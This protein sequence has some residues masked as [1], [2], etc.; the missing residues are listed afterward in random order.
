MQSKRPKTKYYYSYGNVV[1]ASYL[2]EF[3]RQAL[4]AVG[5]LPLKLN[6]S[7]YE[8]ESVI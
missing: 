3:I 2:R 4:T 5:I 1:I 6:R 8:R 7:F